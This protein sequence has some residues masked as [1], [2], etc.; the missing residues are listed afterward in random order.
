MTKQASKTI[1]KPAAKSAPAKPAPTLA[2]MAKAVGITTEAAAKTIAKSK[3]GAAAETPAPAVKKAAEKPAVALKNRVAAKGAQ[4]YVATDSAR[5]AVGKVLAAH[6]HAALT[7]LGML[8]PS[9]PASSRSAV[10]TVIGARAVKYHMGEGN[11]EDTADNGLRLS[12]AGYSKLQA[13][14]SEGKIDVG[15]ANAFMDM[16]LDGNVTGTPVAKANI[17]PVKF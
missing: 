1:P 2:Q 8:Q 13:R 16:F 7:V 12:S 15:A 3:K 17:Y 10:S 11:F 5:P 9:R 14:V 6:T 4:L